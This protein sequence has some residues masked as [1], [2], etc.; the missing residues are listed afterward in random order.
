M[1]KFKTKSRFDGRGV[2]LDNDQ[3][4]IP[5]NEMHHQTKEQ[6]V[7]YTGKMRSV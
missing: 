3:S 2:E 7:K 5:E 6:P 1:F 4:Q